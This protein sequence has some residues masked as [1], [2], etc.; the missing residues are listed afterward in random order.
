MI[1][2]LGESDPEGIPLRPSA[3]QPA[4]VDGSKATL[5]AR[6]QRLSP[7]AEFLLHFL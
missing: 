2:S 5:L 7:V 4:Y 6:R 3:Y 1:L